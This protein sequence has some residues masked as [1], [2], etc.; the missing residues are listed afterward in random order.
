MS[1]K[2]IEW[3]T[4]KR[5]ISD[6][7]EYD[8]NP[9]TLSEKQYADLKKS[10]T[11]FDLAEIP[12]IDTDNRIAAGHQ[13]LRVLSEIKGKDYEIDVRVPNRKLTEAEF[14][15]YN[16]RSNKNTGSWNFEVLAN[17]FE[18]ESLLEFGFEEFEFG[19]DKEI[20]D[21]EESSNDQSSKKKE[22]ECPSCGE[23]IFV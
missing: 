16:I 23:I 14:E 2:K 15:E 18:I 3:T 17:E 7:I 11:K 1:S 8:K 19:I 6:L 22:I 9:R 13:R 21:N 12:V 5:K 10:L 20:E 4:E